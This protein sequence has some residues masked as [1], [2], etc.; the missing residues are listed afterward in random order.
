MAT[1][2]A[3]SAP[4][5]IWKP[6]AGPQSWLLQCPFPDI[7][8][9]G[10]RGGGK[11]HGMCGHWLK[12]AE[13]YG[14]N[15]QGIWFRRSLPEIEGA[16]K[17]MRELFTAVGAEYDVQPRIWR[18]PNGAVLK[19][20]YLESDADAYRY[21][22]H[23]F[24]VEYF[25]DVGTWQ[26]PDPIDLLRGCLRSSAGVPCGTVASANPCGPGHEWIKARYLTPA[27]PMTPHVADGITRI[28]IPSTLKDNPSLYAD[29]TAR[30]QYLAQLRLAGPAHIVAA[31]IDG[32]WDVEPGGAMVDPAWLEHTYDELPARR[33]NRLII[34]VDPAEDIGVNN[35][36]TGIVGGLVAGYNA[37]LMLTEGVKLLLDPLER[38]LEEIGRALNP[39]LFVVEKKSV[40]GPLVQNLKRRPG[41]RWPVIARDPGRLSKA[42]RMWAQVP[43]LQGGR[44]LVP[45]A[46][47]MNGLP[48]QSNI[49][50]FKR[51]VTRFTG[52]KKM[53]EK[54][55]QVDAL[56]QFLAEAFGGEYN[57]AA[58][59]RA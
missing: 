31:W 55:N 10:A 51:E 8:V 38:R 23:E 58:M 5:V 6:H 4:P 19:L 30:E 50:A 21:V 13:K 24:S 27:R 42:E 25:D 47:M 46:R 11:T 39:D 45:S 49:S 54:D 43:H 37:H 56:S 34:S 29:Q 36:E 41:W 48:L 18:F 3:S 7:L 53:N 44:V 16:Q 1:R 22:G 12:H 9:G 57:L 14:K 20:R 35:D 32:D 52:N 17:T 15:A 2:M 28:Y 26:R 33:G 59:T 40:G